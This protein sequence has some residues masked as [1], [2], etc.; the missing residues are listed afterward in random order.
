MNA[1]LRM[2]LENAERTLAQALE[3]AAKDREEAMASPDDAAFDSA[4]SV[5]NA[6]DNALR[7]MRK[8]L[9]E[10]EAV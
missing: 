5:H 8:A 6:V 10:R 1:V 7:D 9:L 4:A 3:L 2:Y